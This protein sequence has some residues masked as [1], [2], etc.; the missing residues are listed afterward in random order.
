MFA[1]GGAHSARIVGS[2]GS[3]HAALCILT[4]TRA[5]FDSGPPV[6]PR[7]DDGSDSGATGYSSAKRPEWCRN[8]GEPRRAVL[9]SCHNVRNPG[10]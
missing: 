7:L 10:V 3:E 2:P 1:G 6:C 9:P 5:I 4:G 8:L